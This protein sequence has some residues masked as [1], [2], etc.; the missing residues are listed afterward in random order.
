MTFSSLSKRNT[1][2]VI[3]MEL[4]I[5]KKLPEIKLYTKEECNLIV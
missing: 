1:T 2:Q 4:Y 5:F 3:E